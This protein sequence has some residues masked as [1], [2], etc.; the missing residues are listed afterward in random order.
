[1]QPGRIHIISGKEFDSVPR[2]SISAFDLFLPFAATN[3]SF[4]TEEQQ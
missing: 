2:V 4:F 1:M 3:E